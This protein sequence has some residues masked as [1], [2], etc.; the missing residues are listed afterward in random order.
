[1]FFLSGVKAEVGSEVN[2]AATSLPVVGARE[3]LLS[4]FPIASPAAAATVTI[5]P[6]VASVAAAAE[7]GGGQAATSRMIT[8]KDLAA[9]LRPQLEKQLG[10]DVALTC[11]TVERLVGPW[12]PA[13]LSPHRLAA[14]VNE[15]VT[16]NNTNKQDDNN[17]Q[18]D[19]SRSSGDPNDD[20][21]FSTGV[22]R[23]AISDSSLTRLAGALISNNDDCN[24]AA[25]SIP[26]RKD[27]YF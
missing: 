14:L 25:T 20:E 15:F 21:L 5:K 17:P 12:A 1:V 9:L 2:A 26:P 10:G 23:T 11:D 13:T 18:C 7:L 8:A 19:S 3:T 24:L 16:A 6:E 4:A 27:G 22:T